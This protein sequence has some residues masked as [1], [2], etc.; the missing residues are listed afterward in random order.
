[1]GADYRRSVHRGRQRR[2][3][4]PGHAS[5][6]PAGPLAVVDAT[7]A[8][9]GATAALGQV[10]AWLGSRPLDEPLVVRRIAH[11]MLWEEGSQQQDALARMEALRAL[12]G[13]GDQAA[14][15]E[16]ARAV[17]PADG[18]QSRA[19]A[20]TGN[21]RAVPSLIDELNNPG[22]PVT[23][24]NALGASGSPQAIPPLE[25]LL[26]DDRIEVRAAAAEA[27]GRIGSRDVVT[28]VKPMLS[29]HNVFVRTKAAEALLRLDDESGLAMLEQMLQDPDSEIRLSA[30]EAL[31]SRADSAWQSAVYQL[32]QDEDPRRPRRGGAPSGDSRSRHGPGDARVAGGRRERGRQGAGGTQTRG[33]RHQRPPWSSQNDACAGPIDAGKS[34][35]RGPPANL[36]RLGRTPVPSAGYRLTAGG[37]LIIMLG[38]VGR[39]AFCG[40]RQLP[41]ISSF[42]F[43]GPK[44]HG[45]SLR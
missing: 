30:A 10:Q 18:A 9:A 29:D 27:L 12:A 19:A 25:G 23:T 26:K 11:A 3:D 15:S 7:I 43:A 6:Q 44:V 40:P 21:A 38:L 41:K 24:I 45:L 17:S 39:R 28:Q 33:R 8:S 5:A 35:S 37:S 14:A 42:F 22:S 36:V 31:A 1:M 4:V 2:R 32:L 13:D 16:L 20:A 34:S